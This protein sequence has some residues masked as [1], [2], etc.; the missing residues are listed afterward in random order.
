MTAAKKTE[1]TIELIERRLQAVKD[2]KMGFLKG[3]LVS[4]LHTINNRI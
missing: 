1:L 3:L 2:K 4:V